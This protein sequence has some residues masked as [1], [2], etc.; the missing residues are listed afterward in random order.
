M[1]ANAPSNRNIEADVL[2]ST[3]SG[4]S[5]KKRLTMMSIKSHGHLIAMKTTFLKMLRWSCIQLLHEVVYNNITLLNKKVQM[6]PLK[7][8]LKL[9][10]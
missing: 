2:D 4:R 1:I 6:R 7:P 8:F 3:N 10:N 5:I 9:L